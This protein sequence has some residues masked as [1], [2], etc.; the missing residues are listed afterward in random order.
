MKKDKY[1]QIFNYLLEFSKL[2]SNPVRDIESSETQYPETL[3]LADI[4]QHDIF[5][6]ITFTN[7]LFF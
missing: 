2:R 4:P 3:W 5:D 7:D 1:L 6:C